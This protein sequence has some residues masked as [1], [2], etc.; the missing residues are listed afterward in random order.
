M[1]LSHYG[2]WNDWDEGT[3]QDNETVAVRATLGLAESGRNYLQW[4]AMDIAGNGFTT[5]PHYRVR[6]DVT[7]VEFSGL[8]PGEGRPQNRTDVTCSA[9]V[10]DRAGGSGVDLP[11]IE[12]R[13]GYE[14][15]AGT[16]WSD[17]TGAGME[18][19]R[20]ST[21]FS[22]VLQLRH[23]PSN[24]VQLRGGDV[25]G[26]GPTPSPVFK[27]VV[28][29]INP[30]FVAVTPPSSEKQADPDVLVTLTLRDDFTGV[31]CA[32]VEY[33]TGQGPSH[34]GG[35]GPMA[36]VPQALGNFSGSVR[37]LLAPG[38]DNCIQFRAVDL[39][40]N[41]ATSAISSVWVNR[42]PVAVIASPLEDDAL[43][44]GETVWLGANG[45]TDPDGDGLAY[46]W[47][48]D[49]TVVPGATTG[50]ENVTL[51]EGYHNVTLVLEDDVGARGTANVLVHVERS[52]NPR[53]RE[54][55]RTMLMPLLLV[56][57]VACALVAVFY[58]YGRQRTDR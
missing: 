51:A 36:V 11:S 34:L 8:E 7:P 10:L 26:N 23:G 16:E 58:F 39:A 25:A 41:A 4:R 45:S 48:V 53:A 22:F 29:T 9:T 27:V 42:P 55:D 24:L 40:G 6:T 52:A 35:W 14:G 1:N 50:W 56:I 38:R 46:S 2:P 44:E 5:S 37:I 28:D 19:A 57:V 12:Y 49:G 54:D 3:V 15:A 18:G 20:M 43:I 13:W 31:D 17:W 47:L 32:R 33:R 21:W 30:E